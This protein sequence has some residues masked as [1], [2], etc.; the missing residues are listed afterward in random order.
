MMM[1]LYYVSFIKDV[2]SMV[3]AFFS[4]LVVGG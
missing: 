4:W 1:I 3:M 2:V